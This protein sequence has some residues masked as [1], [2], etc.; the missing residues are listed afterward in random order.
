MSNNS[1]LI[2]REAVIRAIRNHINVNRERA[3][4]GYAAMIREEDIKIIEGVQSD[5]PVGDWVGK[6]SEPCG[7]RDF[8][9]AECSVCGECYVL[10]E[11]GIDDIKQCF[12]YCPN[13]GARMYKTND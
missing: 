11:Y 9:C 3:D 2:S 4:R 10:D 7:W 12:N 6:S 5:E 8:D 1:D 13:C